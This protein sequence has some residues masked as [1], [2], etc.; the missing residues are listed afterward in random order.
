M[1]GLRGGCCDGVRC[2]C[3]SLGDVGGYNYSCV[4][5]AAKALF[6]GAV[7]DGDVG[8]VVT[9]ECA[10]AA[11]SMFA[12]TAEGSSNIVVISNRILLRGLCT[13]CGGWSLLRVV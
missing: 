8:V 10:K 2:A 3:L 13:D 7:E 12:A 6:R 5:A 1:S 4:S 9:S 11:S